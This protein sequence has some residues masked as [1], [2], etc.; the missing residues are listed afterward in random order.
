MSPP[1][2][3]ENIS[4]IFH[5]YLYWG[6]VCAPL[7]AHLDNP[8]QF[9][10]VNQSFPFL[11]HATK[12]TFSSFQTYFWSHFLL[13]CSPAFHPFSPSTQL[14]NQ[15]HLLFCRPF[16]APISCLI[17]PAFCNPLFTFSPSACFPNPTLRRIQIMPIS[18]PSLLLFYSLL[19]SH[20]I[21]PAFSSFFFFFLSL[22]HRQFTF[23]CLL[24][25]PVLQSPFHTHPVI[26]CVTVS[27]GWI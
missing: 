16:H 10:H 5:I 2:T 9:P 21:L 24:F 22:A 12:F 17:L 25:S 1:H 20:L 15:H 13:L 11:T 19:C 8:P 18:V 26:M 7:L 27:L 4:L 14:W 23:P 6:G 3:D